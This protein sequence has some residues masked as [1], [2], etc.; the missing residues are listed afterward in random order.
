MTMLNL[1]MRRRSMLCGAAAVIAATLIGAS[2]QAADKVTFTTNWFAQAEHGGYYQ[3]KATG[4]YD[5]AGL[6]VTI[7][8]GGP[9]VNVMQL[10]VAGETDI[11]MGYDL[12]TLSSVE[13][14]LPVVAVAATF[15]SD[16]RCIMARADVKSLADLKGKTILV[17]SGGRTEWWPWLKAKYGYTDEQS[18]PYTFNLQPFF[19]DPNV[20]QQ[21]FISSEPLQAK[22]QGVA[23]NVF[24]LA[25]EGYPP[26]GS[27]VVTTRQYLEKNRDV[28][29]RFV[30]A[31][32]QGWRD[33]LKDPAPASRLIKE[34]NPNMK[35][36]QI[37]YAV[38]QLKAFGVVDGGD[39]KTKG[40]GAI[41]EPRWEQ[42]YKFM[43]GSGLLGKDTEWKKAFTTEI[44]DKVKVLPQ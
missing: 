2:T 22:N 12:Q 30:E 29:R 3:A 24:L 6:D 41:T 9:Q 17:A 8:M 26:Y 11:I 19:S 10:L 5:K 1:G 38:E 18:R 15:Q 32:M 35:D 27:P 40:I 16:L 43:V 13:K 23:V 14:G 39:A 33:F 36:E 25:R 28:V 4:L 42:T 21:C 31:S 44:V 7:K 20:V 34:A 37:A